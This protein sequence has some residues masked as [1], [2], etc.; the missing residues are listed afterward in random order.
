MSRAHKL[1]PPMSLIDARTCRPGAESHPT[2]HHLP[3]CVGGVFLLPNP[4]VMW[5]PTSTSLERGFER[6]SDLVQ[7][8]I[9]E[10][11]G[12]DLQS[13]RQ[14]GIVCQTGRQG[15]AAQARQVERQGA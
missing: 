10:C 5:A 1:T 2:S 8:V 12:H 6:C 13:D 3:W 15:H 4:K 14:V 11:R 9:G 7:A